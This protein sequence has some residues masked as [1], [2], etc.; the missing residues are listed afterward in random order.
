MGQT[1][2]AKLEER[3]DFVSGKIEYYET[4]FDYAESGSIFGATDEDIEFGL[5]QLAEYQAELDRLENELAI[6][7]EEL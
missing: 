2:I 4:M 6:A 3:I 5:Q 1:E 7:I